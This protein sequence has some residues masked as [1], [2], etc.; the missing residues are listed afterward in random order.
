[1]RHKIAQAA[2][3]P[4]QGVHRVASGGRR[5]QALEI[6][7]EGWIL[8][9]LPLA[10]T[11]LLTDSP[12]RSRHFVANIRQSAINRGPCQAGNLRHQTDT[13]MTHSLRFQSYE[14]PSALLIQNRRHLHISLAGSAHLRSANHA[15]TLRQ[16]IPSC[17]SPSKV[18]PSLA[19]NS[20]SLDYGRG[21]TG[22]HG[23]EEKMFQRSIIIIGYERNLV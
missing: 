16:A 10:P 7:H 3:R 6:N 14:T 9:C 17:E 8:D 5:N 21:L 15:A 22:F 1:L 2:A 13:A 20:D 11:A 23:L 4:Q 19:G 12:R 18:F